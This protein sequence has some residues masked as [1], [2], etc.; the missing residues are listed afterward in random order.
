MNLQSISGGCGVGWRRPEATQSLTELRW[1]IRGHNG[2]R[3]TGCQA[4]GDSEGRKKIRS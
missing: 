3:M 1:W 2:D 4:S